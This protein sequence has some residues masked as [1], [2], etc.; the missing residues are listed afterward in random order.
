[1]DFHLEFDEQLKV[2][3]GVAT[4]KF[5]IDEVLECQRT[6]QS[7]IIRTFVPGYSDIKTELERRSASV[8]DSPQAREAIF[9]LRQQLRFVR[10]K[11]W[12]REIDALIGEGAVI[13]TEWILP[14]I[15]DMEQ[16]AECLEKCFDLLLSNF[17]SRLRNR[18]DIFRDNPRA[19][20]TISLT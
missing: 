10:M 14:Q 3:G 16:A 9:A 8:I 19:L 15:G 1:K 12:G 13:F 11:V 6:N 20:F 18:L 5:L 2:R 7:L 4:L 17:P